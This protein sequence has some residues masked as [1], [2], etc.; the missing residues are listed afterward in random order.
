MTGPSITIGASSPKSRRPAMKGVALQWPWGMPA[1]R[2]SPRG[3]RPRSRAILVLSPFG[4]AREPM[5]RSRL[6]VDEDQ[7][8]R[9]RDPAAPR[10]SSRGPSG[11]RRGPARSRGQTFFEH[12]AV[13]PEEPVHRRGGETPPLLALEAHGDLGERDVGRLFEH[14]ED[15]AAKFLDTPRPLVTTLLP[16]RHRPVSR[17][18]RCH[19]T[20]ADSAT[21]NRAAADR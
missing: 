21:P 18:S 19:F 20:A 11:H 8:L 7:A 12:P 1:R 15:R 14:G 17:Q 5:A 2:H 13:A 4:A 10:T 16:R 9:G 6:T 3:A